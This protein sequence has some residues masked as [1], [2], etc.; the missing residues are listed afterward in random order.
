TVTIPL[1]SPSALEAS[2]QTKLAYDSG[3]T[4]ILLVESDDS[5]LEVTTEALG[6][7]GMAVRAARN[8]YEAI[9]I[10]K[11]ESF[12]AAI[13]DVKL[14]GETSTSALYSWIEQNRRELAGRVIFTASSR[15]DPAA[16]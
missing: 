5:V 14:T 11:Q 3:S 13:L 9:E 8:G 15:Q 6:K 7:R 12:D 2:E 4:R 16:I 10:L 1:I